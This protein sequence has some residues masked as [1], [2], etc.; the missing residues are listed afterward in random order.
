[1][2]RRTYPKKSRGMQ[3]VTAGW[4]SWRWLAGVSSKEKQ[5]FLGTLMGRSGYESW[6][7]HL[8]RGLQDAT[9]LLKFEETSDPW[10]RSKL[11]GQKISEL[12]KTYVVMSDEER[13]ELARQAE[14]ELRTG[15]ELMRK[16]KKII[17]ELIAL[18]D[19]PTSK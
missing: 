11:V 15:L 19:P 17:Q 1:M 3:R 13:A 6:M 14:V 12:R 2:E 9:F 8:T 5:W 16:D 10:E 18:V 4:A 7:A